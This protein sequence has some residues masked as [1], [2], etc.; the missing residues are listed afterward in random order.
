V[1]TLS[2]D[3]PADR[4]SAAQN[5]LTALYRAVQAGDVATVR[6]LLEQNPSLMSA[7]GPSGESLA[8]TAMYAGH[9]RLADELGA[10]LSPLPIFEAVAFEETER[11]AGLIQAEPGLITS[12]SPDGWQPLHLAAMFGRAE[13]ARALLDADAPVAEKSV[14][15]AARTPLGLAASGGHA[16]LV[17]ILVA[18]D[19]PLDVA[20]AQGRTA[21]MLAARAGDAE[22]VRA[23]LA[24]GAERDL[25]DTDGLSAAELAVTP[26]ISAMLR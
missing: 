16:E 8:L 22:S 20:D 15:Q 3:D 4:A 2:S 17:W 25:I 12:W 21:L 1:S 14:N 24:A 9:S 26:D 19:A 11:L 7:S 13:A 10:N 18:S 23:L 5:L 6:Q